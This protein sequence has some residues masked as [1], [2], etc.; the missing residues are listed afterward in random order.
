MANSSMLILELNI[1]VC[2]CFSGHIITLQ[3]RLYSHFQYL[4]KFLE[5][6]GAENDDAGFLYANQ[7]KNA[8]LAKAPPPKPKRV[9]EFLNIKVE[10]DYQRSCLQSLYRDVFPSTLCKTRSPVNRDR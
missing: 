7:V 1:I 4:V 10:N 9:E 2:R 8:S 5:S 6:Y 3:M